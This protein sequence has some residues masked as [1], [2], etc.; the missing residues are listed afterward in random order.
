VARLGV[1]RKFQIPSVFAELTVGDNLAVALWSGRAAAR[2]LLRPSL[3]RWDSDT[4][5]ALRERFAFLADRARPAA[6]LSH[7]ERQLLE[8]VMALVSEPRLLLLDEPSGGLSPGETQA[9][10]DAVR[11][12]RR[13]LATTVVIIEHDMALVK[14]LA[15]HVF[16]LHQ[17]RLLAEGD[18]ATVRADRRV[19]EVYVGVSE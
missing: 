6:A 5:S 7:G 19:H 11:W 3:R 15:D 13:T 1:G 12:A 10:I 9:V 18:V 2:Q 4:L 16:V 8:L 14:A 17:G